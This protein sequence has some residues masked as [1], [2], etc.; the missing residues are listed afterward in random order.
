MFRSF[1]PDDL[2][3][4]TSAAY[5]NGASQAFGYDI[6]SRLS[7]LT[8]NLSGT[9]NDLTKTFTNTNSGDTILISRSRFAL[10]EFRGHNTN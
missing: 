9:A 3:N 2:G 8:V 1:D 7:S 6:V 5:G 10:P 4:R